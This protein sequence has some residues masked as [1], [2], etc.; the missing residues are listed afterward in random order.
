MHR[1]EQAVLVFCYAGVEIIP[2]DGNAATLSR[3]TLAALS[4]GQTHD[5]DVMLGNTEK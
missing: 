4:E 1:R 3:E 5:L 2:R